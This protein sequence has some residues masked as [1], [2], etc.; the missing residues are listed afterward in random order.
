MN[1]FYEFHSYFSSLFR[2]RVPTGN[3]HRT[4]ESSASEHRHQHQESE[5][6]HHISNGTNHSD[7]SEQS[8]ENSDFVTIDVVPTHAVNQGSGN[9]KGRRAQNY[10]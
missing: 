10:S 5:D 8:G 6:K 2:L 1:F 3:T 9:S 7:A 4:D